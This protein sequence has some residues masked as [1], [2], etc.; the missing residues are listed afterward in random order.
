M[1]VVK[2]NA[3]KDI[4]M[5]MILNRMR[6]SMYMAP[7]YNAGGVLERGNIELTNRPIV[8]NPDGTSSTVRSMS[9]NEN[10]RE[11]LIP[12]VS[13]DGKIL[14]DDDAIKVYRTTGRHLGIFK[15]P[16]LATIYAQHLHDSYEKHKIPGY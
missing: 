5:G 12:T 11:I 8:R 13:E 9:I 1:P 15:S 6:Q 14:S 3:I 4:V 2:S 7:G 16:A 10:G